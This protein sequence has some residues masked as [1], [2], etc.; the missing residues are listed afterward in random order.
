MQSKLHKFLCT[1]AVILALLCSWQ[2]IAQEQVALELEHESENSELE[3][4]S[5]DEH[6][7]V[8]DLSTLQ[9]RRF[10]KSKKFELT[11]SIAVI[12]SDIFVIYLPLTL[13]LAYHFNEAVSLDFQASYMGCFS[14]KVGKSQTRAASEHCLRFL[15][16]GYERLTGRYQSATQIRNIAI[17]EWQVARFHLNP[18]WAP[19]YGKFSLANKSIVHFDLHITAGIGLLLVETIGREDAQKVKLHPVFEGNLGFGMKFFFHDFLGLRFDYRSYLFPKQR[20]KGL[21]TASE[22]SVGLSFL[23]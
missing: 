20:K 14:G 18:I 21:G 17:Q 23:L 1:T 9:S 5:A 15:S 13:R 22:L 4:M 7:K 16:A 19:F 2:A 6:A 11:P 3:D 10:S 12:A 8:Y